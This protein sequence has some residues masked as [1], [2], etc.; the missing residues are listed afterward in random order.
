MG[1]Q[2]AIGGCLQLAW[3]SM[4]FSGGC[5]RPGS[6]STYCGFSRK[7][8]MPLWR[9][10]AGRSETMGGGRSNFY[11]DIIVDPASCST[12]HKIKIE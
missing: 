7:T 11:A 1:R 9:L 3:R 2:G 5:R 8:A 10:R 6:L 12:F 4:T